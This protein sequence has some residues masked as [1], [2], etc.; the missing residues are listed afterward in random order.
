MPTRPCSNALAKVYCRLNFPDR[1]VSGRG[2]LTYCITGVVSVTARNILFTAANGVHFTLS[3][4]D[5]ELVI[6]SGTADVPVIPAGG[7]V[8]LPPFVCRVADWTTARTVVLKLSWV[9]NGNEADAAA[10]RTTVYPST[11]LWLTSWSPSTLPL[12]SVRAVSKDIAWASGGSG[13]ATDAVVVRTTNGGSVWESV[14]SNLPAVD[15]YCIEAVD[16]DHAWV[17]TGGGAIYATTNGGQSWSAQPYPG[18]QSGFIDAIRFF[19]LQNGYALG[20]PPSGS[21]KFVLLRT[22]DGGASW[23]HFTNE[24]V[25]VTGEVGWINSF[26]WSDPRHGWFG[27][28]VSRV[29]RTSDGGGS[30]QSAASGASSSYA[31]TF[32][33]SL[34]GIVGHESGLVARST[35]GGLSWSPVAFP[36]TETLTGASSVLGQPMTWAATS[37]QIYRTTDD[38][39]T[40][41]SQLA[42]P[43]T[44]GINHI[45]LADTSHGWAVTSNGEVI[46]YSPSGGGTAVEPEPLPAEYRLSQNYP[47]PFNPTTVITY[48]LA[49]AG[50]VRLA[51]YDLLGREV[52]VLL[53]GRQDPGSHTVTFN[54]RGLAS[55][56]Y[57]YRL[58]AGDFAAVR[59]MVYMK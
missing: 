39:T 28:N 1:P 16:A 33:D 19:D 51:V 40:W 11:P 53:R 18:I 41:V 43:F 20:D 38:G 57:F 35:D 45:S 10:F 9:S 56:V 17:G 8:L 3:S 55:G 25:G 47:N 5:P 21:S 31:V 4:F 23:S 46:A 52:A 26:A 50:E 36:S 22:T 48:Q 44:G 49:V 13:S 14:S 54:A 30:W 34:R 32:R 7:E 37:T 29:W 2:R 12:F 15:L 42:S 24:P 59:K 6:L 58:T 27:T